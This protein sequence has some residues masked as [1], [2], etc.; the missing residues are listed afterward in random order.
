MR[1]ERSYPRESEPEEADAIETF[2]LVAGLERVEFT[3][4]SGQ[5]RTSNEASLVGSCQNG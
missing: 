3:V 1:T 2:A 4:C 5:P